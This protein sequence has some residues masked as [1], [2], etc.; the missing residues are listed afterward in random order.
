MNRRKFITAATAGLL[1]ATPA[2]KAS[3]LVRDFG[4]PSH[5]I[6]RRTL[7]L[8]VAPQGLETRTMVLKFTVSESGD[9]K[10]EI[11]ETAP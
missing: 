11:A 4:A 8:A 2:M 6:E 5:V 10:W 7:E 9:N 3:A 1:M